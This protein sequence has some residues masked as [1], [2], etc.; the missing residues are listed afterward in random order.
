MLVYQRV[1]LG[2][3]SSST[4]G[5]YQFAKYFFQPPAPG[6]GLL[7]SGH[8]AWKMF[9]GSIWVGIVPKMIQPTKLDCVK[10]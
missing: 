9:G 8:H 6:F 5:F 2:C 7:V 10:V 1:V 4:L 3:K